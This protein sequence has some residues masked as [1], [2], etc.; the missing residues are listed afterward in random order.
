MSV[1]IC[2]LTAFGA[3]RAI[4]GLVTRPVAFLLIDFGS[5]QSQVAIVLPLQYDF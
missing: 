4:K 3:R 5:F 2:V 1:L